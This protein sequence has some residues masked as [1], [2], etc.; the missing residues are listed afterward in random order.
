MIE[1]SPV[2]GRHA[3]LLHDRDLVKI[4]S[5]QDKLVKSNLNDRVSVATNK[6]TI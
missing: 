2:H 6:L 5:K 4:S 1:G 3:K